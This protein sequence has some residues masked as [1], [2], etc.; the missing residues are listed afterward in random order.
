M[1]AKKAKPLTSARA[2]KI[3]ARTPSNVSQLKNV[4]YR[5][6]EPWKAR[7]WKMLTDMDLPPDSLRGVLYSAP[8][9]YRL[10]AAELMVATGIRDLGTVLHHAL[11]VGK[12]IAAAVILARGATPTEL[13][14]LMRCAP[15][16]Y[17]RVAQRAYTAV[18]F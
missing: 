15:E 14:L 6:P 10:R 2:R 8:T 4:L 3:L 12:R 7:A 17:R 9:T 16:P 13:R 18:A 5:A 1:W 11:A